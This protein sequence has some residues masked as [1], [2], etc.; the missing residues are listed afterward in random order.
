LA[1]PAHADTGETQFVSDLDAAGI[2][3]RDGNSQSL[4]KGWPDPD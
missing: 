2:D 3:S 1:A 4:I